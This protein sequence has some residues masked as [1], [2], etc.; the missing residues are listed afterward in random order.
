MTHIASPP[1]RLLYTDRQSNRTE[2]NNLS[3]VFHSGGRMPS[4]NQRPIDTNSKSL[5]ELLIGFR[6]GERVYV[7][8]DGSNTYNSA[9]GLNFTIDYGRLRNVFD[10]NTI[11]QRIYYFTALPSDDQ[12]SQLRRQVDWMKH[13]GY[14]VIH[15]PVKEYTNGDTSLLKGNVDVELTVTALELCHHVDHIVLFTGDG[16]FRSLVEALQNHGK[17]VTVVSTTRTNPA[18][19]SDDLRKQTDFFI[20][21]DQL[22]PYIARVD[23]NP[24][25]T[26]VNKE[27]SSKQEVA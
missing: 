3:Y 15:K 25:S 20:E 26:C 8:I 16:D 24:T 2:T 18:L 6:P 21:L 4:S 11:L 17:R 12:Q 14:S 7:F 1:V 5:N 13:N 9:R 19:A 10:D 27:D 22:R 23:R